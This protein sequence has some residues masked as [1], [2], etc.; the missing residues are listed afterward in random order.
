MDKRHFPRDSAVAGFPQGKVFL[1]P[2][3]VSLHGV[4]MKV[5]KSAPQHRFLPL[6][7][8]FC[9]F[10]S[11]SLGSGGAAA[12]DTVFYTSPVGSKPQILREFEK[13]PKKWMAGHR[14]I[15]I[16]AEG[17]TPVLAPASGEVVFSGRV[18]DR[19]V[20]TI[21]HDDERLSSFEPVVEP[22]PRGSRVEAGQQ[23]ALLDPDIRHC[24]DDVSCLHWGV[25]QDE[26]DYINPLLLLGLE[27]PSVLLPVGEDFAA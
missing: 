14:G 3:P 7:L 5:F 8:L 15:D 13:P 10:V 6:L 9:L 27:E 11:L 20:I 23:I 12:S 19:T 1:A 16:A 26:D 17:R 22:S 18:V 24:S 2:E 25:R 21:R 4:L